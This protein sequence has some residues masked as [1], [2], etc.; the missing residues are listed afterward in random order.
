MI[1]AVSERRLERVKAMARN[2]NTT[3]LIIQQYNTQIQFPKRVVI[4]SWEHRRS[5]RGTSAVEWGP[6]T[7]P[8]TPSKEASSLFKYIHIVYVCIYT[9][10]I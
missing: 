3:T 1:A 9:Y 6:W 10:S 8:S 5:N 4:L 7:N 2:R